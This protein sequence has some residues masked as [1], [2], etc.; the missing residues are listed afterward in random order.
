MAGLNHP[1]RFGMVRLLISTSRPEGTSRA[2]PPRVADPLA[3]KA[4]GVRP[5]PLGTP[6]R[7]AFGIDADSRP[8][9]QESPR[10][11]QPS[12]ERREPGSAP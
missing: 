7:H 12:L 11:I 4:P 5:A 3:A 8:D 6:L 10:F 2:P 9:D 1:R